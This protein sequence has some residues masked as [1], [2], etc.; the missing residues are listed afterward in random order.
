MPSS[1]K[2]LGQSKSL[3]SG[4]ASST[5][6]CTPMAVQ[7]MLPIL[8]WLPDYSMQWLKMDF[9]AGLSV[10]LTVIPQALA[11]A[12]VAGLPPQVRFLAPL[13]AMSPHSLIPH[14]VPQCLS[15]GR[16]ETGRMESRRMHTSYPRGPRIP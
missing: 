7:K 11:Y 13:P 2:T 6:C 8:A 16:V 14:S 15:T 5:C 10:G 1:V 9:I 4:M 3:G 12:E